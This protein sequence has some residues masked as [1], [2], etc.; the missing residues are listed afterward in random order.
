MTYDHSATS[1]HRAAVDH[2][3]DAIRTERVLARSIPHLGIGE[4][5]RRRTGRILIA[6]GTALIGRDSVSLRTHRA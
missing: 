3:I 1:I 2:D 4:R 6:T 5:L